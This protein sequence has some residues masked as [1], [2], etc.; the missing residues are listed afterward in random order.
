MRHGISTANEIGI[1]ISNVQEGTSGYGLSQ[2]GRKQVTSAGKEA[3]EVHKLD[4]MTCIISSDFTRARETAEI[5]QKI[6]DA[7]DVILTPHLRER[8]FGELDRT[9]D[10][11]TVIT[12]K[13]DIKDGQHKVKD[14]ESA[15]EV[16][17][18][19]TKLI[20]DV[21]KKY[22][23]KNILLVSHGDTL[24]ILQTGFENILPGQ[25]RSV[26]HLYNAEIREMKLRR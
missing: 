14:V 8:Y 3:Q 18:R 17:E 6:L 26:P 5:I 1:L 23:G 25:H 16:L 19:T 24:Q 21:E 9:N 2:E 7:K 15:A 10:Y 22:K 11:N 12:W 4:A 13:D 20:S